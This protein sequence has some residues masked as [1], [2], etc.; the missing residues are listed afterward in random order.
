MKAL[1][2]AGGFIGALLVV[3]ALALAF[4][5]PAGFLTVA[6]QDRVERDTGYRLDIAGSASFSLWPSLR[7]TLTDLTLQ[8]PK[9]RD[10]NNR[11]T[12][13]KLQADMA[14][15]SLWSGRPDIGE[16]II[17]KPTVYLPLLRERLRD[18]A[19]RNRASAKPE[20]APAV[21]VGRVTV[22]DG[23]VILSN[24]RDR[25]ENRLDGIGATASLSDD[26]KIKIAGTARA[27]DRLVTFDVTSVAPAMPIDRQTLPVDFRIGMESAFHGAVAGRADVRLNGSLVMING[28]SGTLGDGDFNGW[29]SVDLASKPLVKVDLDLRRLD[30]AD[31]ALQGSSRTSGWSTSAIDLRGLNYIDARVRLSATDIGISG[32]RLGPLDVETSLAGGVLKATVTNL[33]VYGGQA[34]G[35]VVID[36][37]TGNPAYAMHCDLVGVKALPLLSNLAGF[38]KLDAR[39]Q[40][41][42]ALRSGGASQQAIMSNLSGSAFLLFQDGA[43]RGIN[44][45]QMIRSLTTNPLSGWQDSQ[46]LT[47]DLTQLSASFQVERGQAATSDLNLVGPLVKVTGAGTIDLGNRALAMRVEPKLVMT[48]E[49]QGRT[50]DPI[51]LGIPVVIDGPWSQPRFYPDMA[52]ILDN[53]EAA[54]GKLKQMGQ[55]LFGKDGAGLNN[56]INGIGGL[57]GSATPN[58]AVVPNAAP[59]TAAPNPQ[60]PAAGQSDLLGGQ[61]GAA[62]GNLIQQGLQPSAP[63]Q[64]RS[65]GRTVGP[66]GGAVP[67]LQAPQA[68]QAAPSA[69]A[70][71][72]TAATP[73][74][75]R[76]DNVQDSQP[77]N[78]VLKRIFNR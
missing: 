75:P 74:E 1:K 16:I 70:G 42:L 72:A 22:R 38:G 54:Y 18:N 15:S 73:V 46:E 17:D 11:L 2:I 27:G 24:P 49:G 78:D 69:E 23:A 28:L 34:S 52:G 50:S 40:G 39:M 67:L 62:I 55:G 36:A 35:E 51:G 20:A 77:M 76:D 37:S 29:A 41:K 32:A 4:G 30:I 10:G 53:P 31:S 6:I 8:D 61:L 3:L 63:P 68:D 25:V 14:L 60:A 7:A 59:S 58:G 5:L 44:V 21:R 47:T 26:G 45:A 33:G 48:S 13:G 71:Q 65:R 64:P 19:P 9:D 56:L 43:I 57:I 66:S 12:V